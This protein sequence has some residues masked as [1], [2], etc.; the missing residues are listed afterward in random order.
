MKLLIQLICLLTPS[1]VLAVVSYYARSGSA[2][3]GASFT[4]A[5]VLLVWAAFVASFIFDSRKYI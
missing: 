5:L 3:E 1:T 4:L 2:M